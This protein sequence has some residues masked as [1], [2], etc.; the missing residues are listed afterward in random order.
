MITKGGLQHQQRVT[1]VDLNL[2]EIVDKRVNGADDAGD[3]AAFSGRRVVAAVVDVLC[4]GQCRPE[5]LQSLGLR[6]RLFAHF[7]TRSGATLLGRALPV[8]I[9]INLA[10]QACMAIRFCSKRSWRS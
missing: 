3:R 7:A 6:V 10:D 1:F 5:T 9:S 4:L 2:A 8:A